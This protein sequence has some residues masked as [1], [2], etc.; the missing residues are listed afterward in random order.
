MAATR[1]R[2]RVRIQGAF[3]L[4][5]LLLAA[6]PARALDCAAQSADLTWPAETWGEAVADHVRPEIRALDAYLFPAGLDEAK[7]EGVRTNGLV[8]VQGGTIVHERY[9]RGFGP[10]TP[11]IA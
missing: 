9:A 7:R 8:V 10:E 3:A 2:A 11:H 5:A 1:R 4:A 6:A